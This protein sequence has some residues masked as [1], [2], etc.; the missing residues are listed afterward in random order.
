MEDD[1]AR[2]VQEEAPDEVGA[3][4]P[5]GRQFIDREVTFERRIGHRHRSGAAGDWLRQDA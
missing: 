5:E 4:V 3:H 2:F 1:D